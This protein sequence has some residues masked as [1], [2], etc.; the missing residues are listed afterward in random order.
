MC[1]SLEYKAGKEESSK[2]RNLDET[3]L[4]ISTCRHGIILTAINIFGGENYRYVHFMHKKAFQ[5]NVKFFA[6]DVICKYW[7][8]AKKVG[9]KLE[10]FAYMTEE[11]VPYLSRMHGQTHEMICQV[12]VN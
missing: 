3:G 5:N 11:M 6:Y 4:M 2:F 8:F 7:P 1:G 12:L 10:Q 9:S